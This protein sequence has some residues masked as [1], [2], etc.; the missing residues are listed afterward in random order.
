LRKF[1][2]AAVVVP[3]SGRMSLTP[4][5]RQFVS[6]WNGLNQ[7]ATAVA[8]FFM[9]A[10][11]L[12]T[13][14]VTGTRDSLNAS[15]D[16]ALGALSTAMTQFL[17]FA[18]N[19]VPPSQG[20]AAGGAAPLPAGSPATALS[21]AAQAQF[22]A[23]LANP[24]ADPAGFDAFVASLQSLGFTAA[25]TQLQ[26]AAANTLSPQVTAAL[27][28]AHSAPLSSD[29]NQLNALSAR[30]A[31]LGFPGQ[32]AALSQAAQAVQA[33]QAAAPPMTTTAPGGGGPAPTPT[34]PTAPA[35]PSTLGGIGSLLLYTAPAWL[36]WWLLRR[37][38]K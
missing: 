33:A 11:P 5:Q 3:F 13:A 25:A 35:A 19:G 21:P 4:E 28:Q 6:L 38:R 14:V 30:M 26:T 9:T 2:A 36:T 17:A 24:N 7:A 34:A 27:A 12:S 22:Q 32:A 18:P 20:T 10:P 37:R 1:S 16:A 23:F 29:P 8:T 15:R 31:A